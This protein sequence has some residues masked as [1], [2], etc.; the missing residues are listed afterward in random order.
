[1]TIAYAALRK[2]FVVLALFL[3]AAA[4][5]AVARDAVVEL[6]P[7]GTQVTF[8]LVGNMHTVHG[9]FKLKH[10]TVRFDPATGKASGLVVVDATSGNTDNGSRDHKMH[11]DVLESATYP[12]I[13]FAPEHVQG[14]VLTQ[15]DFKVQVSGTFKLHGASHPLT[16]AMQVHLAEGHLVGDTHFTVPYESWGLKN[17]SNFLLRVNNSVEVSIHSAGQINLYSAK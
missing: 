11:K 17:P 4:T 10:G 13:T 6:D 9:T 3:L 7:A 16:L 5:P 12:E 2:T 15:G 1:M 8:T 14:Q